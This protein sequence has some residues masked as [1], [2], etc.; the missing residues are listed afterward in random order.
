[1]IK[2]TL[3]YCMTQNGSIAGFH[4]RC[5]EIWVVQKPGSFQKPGMYFGEHSHT[6]NRRGP[7]S[8]LLCRNTKDIQGLTQAFGLIL[9]SH[10]WK[11]GFLVS[12]PIL[13][14]TNIHSEEETAQNFMTL[15]LSKESLIPA[16]TTLSCNSR[17]YAPNKKSLKTTGPYFTLPKYF[18]TEEKKGWK[19]LVLSSGFVPSS[20]LLSASKEQNQR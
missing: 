7:H 3:N 15:R 5:V 9:N 19:I 1:M 10:F 12:S 17:L 18:T 20:L 2:L 6:R 4:G 14:S 16:G 8:C 13:S 11:E